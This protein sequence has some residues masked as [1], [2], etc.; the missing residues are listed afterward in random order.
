M[1]ACP[2]ALSNLF[3]SFL[4]GVWVSTRVE[5]PSVDNTVLC[6]LKSAFMK[7]VKIQGVGM[8]LVRDRIRILG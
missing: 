7:L 3:T 6:S 8:D 4:G 2:D 5:R 1:F